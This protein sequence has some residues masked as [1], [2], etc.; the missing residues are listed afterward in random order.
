MDTSATDTCCPSTEPDVVA[1]ITV[2]PLSPVTAF[3]QG[4]PGHAGRRTLRASAVSARVF[5]TLRLS[6]RV[7]LSVES[8]PFC[9]PTS[10]LEDALDLIKEKQKEEEKNAKKVTSKE[11][12]RKPHLE[13]RYSFDMDTLMPKKRPKFTLLH[14][15]RAYF[16]PQVCETPRTYLSRPCHRSIDSCMHSLSIVFTWCAKS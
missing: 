3:G 12:K 8:S 5:G 2:T 4:Q 11:V 10:Y 14:E 6:C 9:R 1:L 13:R 16:D 7:L 15:L